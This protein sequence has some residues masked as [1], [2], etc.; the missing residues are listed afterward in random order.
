MTAP[1]ART[2]QWDTTDRYIVPDHIA[3]AIRLIRGAMKDTLD[4]LGDPCDPWPTGGVRPATYLRDHL[5]TVWADQRGLTHLETD[6][7]WPRAIVYPPDQRPTAG[8]GTQVT[9]WVPLGSSWL[10]MTERRAGRTRV[11]GQVPAG[12]VPWARVPW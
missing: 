4:W 11:G 3:D 8:D 12:S 9:G 2:Y 5:P 6:R 10:A 7:T 1:S